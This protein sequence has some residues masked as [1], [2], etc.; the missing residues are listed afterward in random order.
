M[1]RLDR[2]TALAAALAAEKVTAFVDS[3]Y[4]Q[5]MWSTLRKHPRSVYHMKRPV[6]VVAG[7]LMKAIAV[8]R[9]LS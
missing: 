6:Q 5:A 8:A 7:C 3:W 1:A 4:S 2:D 9:V